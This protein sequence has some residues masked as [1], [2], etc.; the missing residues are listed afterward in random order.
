MSDIATGKDAD[1]SQERLIGAYNDALANSLGN[2]LNRTL[3]MCARFID[4]VLQPKSGSAEPI[5]DWSRKLGVYTTE[6]KKGFEASEISSAFAVIRIAVADLNRSVE[7]TKPWILAKSQDSDSKKRLIAV[8]YGL[9]E[10]L[11]IIA[12]LISPV[13]PRA[14]HGIFDQLN[15]KMELTGKD[16]RFD[17]NDAKWG[18]LPDEHRLG[19]PVPLFPRIET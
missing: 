15:W 1:F 3:Q 10:S 5:V 13:L 9:A 18:G 8:L 11:R 2:L 14:A 6:T 4:G 16:G 7:E 17:L 19:K 12:I